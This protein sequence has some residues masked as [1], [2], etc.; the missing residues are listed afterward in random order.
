MDYS[1]LGSRKQTEKCNH[2]FNCVSE[3]PLP[4][5]ANKPGKDS[6]LAVISKSRGTI[7]QGAEHFPLFI[8]DFV[9][10]DLS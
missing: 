3:Y 5:A 6:G 2:V 4:L 9:A 7:L 10:Y 1:F 8:K